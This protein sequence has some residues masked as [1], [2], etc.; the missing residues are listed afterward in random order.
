VLALAAQAVACSGGCQG[1]G[2]SADGGAARKGFDPFGVRELYPTIPGGR[3]WYLPVDADQTSPEWNTDHAVS[4][5]DEPGVFHVDG[6]K[7]PRLD[8]RSPAGKAWWRNVEITGYVRA[9][10]LLK[11]APQRGHVQKPHWTF[12]AR[13]E[14]HTSARTI[15][16]TDSIDDGVMAPPG[17]ATW[18]G[19]PFVDPYVDARCLGTS[20][21]GLFYANGN[22]EWQKE[23]SHTEGYTLGRARKAS[24]F[25][26]TLGRFFGLKVAIRNFD[27]DAE[28][29]ME[30]WIDRAGDD[31]WEDVAEADDTGAGWFAKNRRIDGCGKPPFDY[32]ADQLVSWAGPYATFRSDNLDYDLKWASVREIAPLP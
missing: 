7:Q 1:G 4:R 31:H 16:A 12:Y 26:P 15:A 19:Y 9:R 23:V 25:V 2:S 13:G 21:K 24:G 14:R 30:M 8:V 27:H 11:D 10:A 32:K 5:T 17:T 20:L 22:V 18:P 3:E 29:H 28:V 6:A